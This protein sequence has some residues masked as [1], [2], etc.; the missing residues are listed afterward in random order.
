MMLENPL[1]YAAAV[2]IT[3]S[4]VSLAYWELHCY[5]N[6]WRHVRNR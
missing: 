6:C 3:E 2:Q 1:F 4:P 5:I